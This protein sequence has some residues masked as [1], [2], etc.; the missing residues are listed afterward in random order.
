MNGDEN[1]ASAHREH[2][3]PGAATG[4]LI[5]QAFATGAW[6]VTPLSRKAKQLPYHVMLLI[7]AAP[8]I[9]EAEA[10]TTP[11]RLS[12][13][14]VTDVCMVIPVFIKY[15]WHGS[16][17]RWDAVLLQILGATIGGWAFWYFDIK[18]PQFILDNP[19]L[20][21][22]VAIII[23][24]VIGVAAAFLLRL[25]WWPFHCRLQPHGG[26]IPFLRGALGTFMWPV[27]LS[28]SGLL[29]FV[30]LTGIGVVWLSL[31]VLNGVPSVK[32]AETPNTVGNPDF[33]LFA[34]EDRYRFTWPASNLMQFYI[35]LD[36]QKNPSISNYPAFILRNRTNTVAYRATAT[37]RSETS[38]DIENAVKTSPRLSKADFLINETSL[39]VN[40]KEMMPFGSFIYY[41][42]QSPR[43]V[44]PV[45]AK[46]EDVYLPIQLWPLIA[47]YL[48]QTIPDGIGETSPPFIATVML[49]WETA[50]GKRQRS[51]RV[52]I[53]ATNAKSST[54]PLPIIDAFLNISLQE[55]AQ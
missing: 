24:A 53:T 52:K 16:G 35:R 2:L 27:I 39:A 21:A 48:T 20:S 9:A 29:A 18:T 45:I 10:H 28:A 3:T 4:R 19:A 43:Q 47:V 36:S 1:L 13:A 23:G 40:S 44:I 34:P 6:L 38:F 54:A 37:W 15:A 49:N 5:R 22:V 25:C 14:G 46:E 42:E 50:E 32:A 26:L 51:Y 31:Q 8:E 33:S 55:I 7:G 17:S 30:L 11:L 12:A 41:L